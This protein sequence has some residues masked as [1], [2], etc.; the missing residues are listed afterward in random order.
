MTGRG[1]PEPGRSRSIWQ[2][3]VAVGW[4]AILL[5]FPW[6]ML[7]TPFFTALA[8]APHWAA[9]IECARMAVADAVVVIAWYGAS[10]MVSR[11][12]WWLLRPSLVPLV[13]YVGGGLTFTIFAELLS[14]WRWKRWSYAPSM[15]VIL[16]V[17]VVPLVQWSVIPLVTLWLARRH[18]EGGSTPAGH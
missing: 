7:Q 1:G 8:T 16:G 4:F 18:V 11:S 5:N 14:V 15:P 10:S 6:E 2:P 13:V 17:G 9:T 3:W 12:R